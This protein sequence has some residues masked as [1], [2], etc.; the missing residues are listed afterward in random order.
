MGRPVGWTGKGSW[1][2]PDLEQETGRRIE[3]GVKADRPGKRIGLS[4]FNQKR[5]V[6]GYEDHCWG[7]QARFELN[8]PHTGF[9]AI[10]SRAGMNET[11]LLEMPKWWGRVSGYVG[12]VFFQNDLNVKIGLSARFWSGY[13]KSFSA[14][15]DI[16]Y[17]VKPAAV[18]D[19]KLSAVVMKDFTFE[20]GVEKSGTKAPSILGISQPAG[21]VWTGI[22]WNLYN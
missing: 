18:L 6:A 22:V 12:H 20:L 13:D 21:Q 9:D 7:T 2:N 8:T 4:V 14:L 17:S 16:F 19:F 3:F 15:D 5:D 11:S 10:I 1:I